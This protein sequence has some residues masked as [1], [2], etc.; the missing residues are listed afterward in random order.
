MVKNG[1]WPAEIPRRPRI[2]Q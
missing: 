1:V 2:C